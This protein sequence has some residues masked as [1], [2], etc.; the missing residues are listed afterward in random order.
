MT[1]ILGSLTGQGI[2]FCIDQTALY[3]WSV[4]LI[5][6][7]ES[8]RFINIP[9]DDRFPKLWISHIGLYIKKFDRS[10]CRLR[11]IHGSVLFIS[12]PIWSNRPTVTLLF[13]SFIL[14]R[15]SIFSE[16]PKDVL[17]ID[18][19]RMSLSKSVRAL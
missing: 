19:L 9:I 3:R 16:C 5:C 10:L 12:C 11:F 17:F 18:S 2:W 15:R 7:S 13:S 4:R 6:G 8:Y 14:P 1:D